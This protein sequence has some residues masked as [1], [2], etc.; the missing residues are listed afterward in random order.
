MKKHI[1]EH[2]DEMNEKHRKCTWEVKDESLQW[3][4]NEMH[5]NHRI[6]VLEHKDEVNAKCKNMHTDIKMKRMQNT[7]SMHKNE[8]MKVYKNKRMK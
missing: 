1:Q 5:S 2:T 7:A 6:C 3:H 4:K 8:R